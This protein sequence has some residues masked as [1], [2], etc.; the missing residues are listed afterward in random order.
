M[1][2]FCHVRRARRVVVVKAVVRYIAGLTSERA[3][4]RMARNVVCGNPIRPARRLAC[5]KSIE[6]EA[7]RQTAQ[8]GDS[9]ARG[10]RPPSRAAAKGKSRE[11]PRNPDRSARPRRRRAARSHR[12][13][14]APAP[15]PAEACG[16]TAGSARRPPPHGRAAR[17]AAARDFGQRVLHEE[18]P[19]ARVRQPAQG[20]P[21]GG[22]GGGGQLARRLRRGRH[23]ART[24]RRRRAG[25]RRRGPLPRDDRGQRPGH[26][27]RAGAE[28]FRQAALRLEVPPDAHGA[29]A[30]G[31][32][33]Q[34]GGDVRPAHDRE[35]DADHL[36]RGVAP[37]G[38]PLRAAARH[39]EER[40][41]RGE[42]GGGGLGPPARHAR[43]DRAGGALHPRA[44]VGRGVP[45]AGGHRQPA[46]D[47]PVRAA[48]RRGAAPRALLERA[49][50]G[51][52]RD[53]AAPV[54]H[55]A[56]D[57]DRHAPVHAL[58]ARRRRSS[59]PISRA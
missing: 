55:R 12:R 25:G 58:A 45:A 53:Q 9:L 50:A 41:D 27:A 16:K 40:A 54:R 33:H 32:R 14:G 36:A 28:D 1:F 59:T 2:V 43:G 52:A 48:G 56:G 10:C 21:D 15:P 51:A 11:P 3:R 5:E 7:G 13:P 30:A 19:S 49:P 24:E 6:Q 8:P 23:S 4:P 47:D 26:R 37:Q 44:P 34:R 17:Q 42:R 35:A 46:R 57:A 38:V 22:E 20:A 18:P 39:E 31:H 29:R